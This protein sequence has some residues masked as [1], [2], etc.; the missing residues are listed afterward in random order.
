MR[1][2]ITALPFL[3]LTTACS[4]T[5]NQTAN[6]P[7]VMGDSTTIVT[8]TDSQYLRSAFADY[9]VANPV[10]AAPVPENPKVDSPTVSVP[11]TDTPVA[12]VVKKPTGP[13]LSA[14]FGDVQVFVENLR[15]RNEDANAKGVRSVA[16][17][18]DG[19]AFRPKNLVVNDGKA[20]G[21]S[22]KQKTDFEVVVNTGKE[23]LPLPSLGKQSTGWQTVSGKGGTFAL[24]EPQAPAFKVTNA[25]IKNAAQQAARKARMSSKEQTALLNRLSRVKT[26]DGDLLQAKPV[27][28]M[29]QV[30]AKDAKGKAVTKE[31]RVDW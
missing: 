22:L 26:V 11:K 31:I 4:Y 3:L 30:T 14:D 25:S 17:S 9:E 7:I 10:E 5:G 12:A 15:V 27:A 28:T 8:E 18:S 24:T 21:A 13:G 6:A 23:L 29:W 2:P 1:L 19:S 16:Y 20:N